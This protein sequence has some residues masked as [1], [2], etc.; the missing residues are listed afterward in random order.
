MAFPSSVVVAPY[1]EPGMEPSERIVTSYVKSLKDTFKD[2]HPKV[3]N[4]IKLADQRNKNLYDD[5]HKRDAI[6]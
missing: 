3:R 5:R 1:P 2:F 6:R 4:N